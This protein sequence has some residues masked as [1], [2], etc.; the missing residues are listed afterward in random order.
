MSLAVSF[1]D[2]PIARRMFFRWADQTAEKVYIYVSRSP[3]EQSAAEST[4]SANRIQIKN[5]EACASEEDGSFSGFRRA[6]AT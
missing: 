1:S 3:V 6:E 2:E 5:S 4:T